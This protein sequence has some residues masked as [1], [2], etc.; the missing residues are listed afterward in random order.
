MQVLSYCCYTRLCERDYEK[1]ACVHGGWTDWSQPLTCSR[2]TLLTPK[3]TRFNASLAEAGRRMRTL[4]WRLRRSFRE[5]SNRTCPVEA[6]LIP[7]TVGSRLVASSRFRKRARSKFPIALGRCGCAPRNFVLFHT[8][9]PCRQIATWGC[10]QE[11]LG[12]MPCP[13]VLR[14]INTGSVIHTR[15]PTLGHDNAC[16][17]I[18]EGT[19]RFRRNPAIWLNSRSCH[20]ENES[21]CCVASVQ[22][23]L[24]RVALEKTLIWY[25]FTRSPTDI[26]GLHNRGF[27]SAEYRKIFLCAMPHCTPA[28]CSWL[29][30]VPTWCLA[31]VRAELHPPNRWSCSSESRPNRLEGL[32][33]RKLRSNPQPCSPKKLCCWRTTEC[34]LRTRGKVTSRRSEHFPTA[35]RWKCNMPFAKCA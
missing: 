20:E 29:C 19:C 13:P 5:H 28:A 17:E 9:C 10:S 1:E 14:Y 4:K 21:S 3:Q 8:F 18:G 27:P 22:Q 25:G 7:R 2:K 23:P 11:N 12:K 33:G 26:I 30:N 16:P 35:G 24:S 34:R 32:P 15:L 31:Q 6:Q